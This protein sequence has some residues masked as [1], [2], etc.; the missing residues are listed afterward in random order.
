MNQLLNDVK[1]AMFPVS[2]EPVTVRLLALPDSA[3]LKLGA[4]RNV[5]TWLVLWSIWMIFSYFFH[6]LGCESSQVTN[7][8]LS[9]GWLSHQAQ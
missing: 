7:S 8:S 4:R 6:I 2:G 3:V 1:M 9:E 5:C